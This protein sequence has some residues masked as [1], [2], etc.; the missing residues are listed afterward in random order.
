MKARSLGDGAAF[1]PEAVKAIGQA[2]DEAWAEIAGNFICPATEEAA[3]LSL[4]NAILSVAIETSRDVQVLKKAALQVLA[5]TYTS[6][7][8]FH[9][10]VR[11]ATNEVGEPR[12]SVGAP[13]F[14]PRPPQR[15]G[16]S[17]TLEG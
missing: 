4:A 9:E 5:G 7:P 17:T 6:L 16:P 14:H 8:I 13:V 15:R 1:G 3:R 12:P 11:E 2:F 10:R